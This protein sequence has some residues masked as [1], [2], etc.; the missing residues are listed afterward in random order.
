VSRELKYDIPGDDC[1]LTLEAAGAQVRQRGWPSLFAPGLASPKRLV[2][3]IGFGRGEFLLQ[4]ARSE[5]E[6]GFLGIERSFKRVLKMARRLAR[7]EIRN[8]RLIESA[9]ES[10]VTEL[11]PPDSVARCWINFPDPWPKKRHH[12][13]RLIAPSFVRDVASRLEPHG[14]LH[15]ATD[16]VEYAEVIDGILAAEPRLENAYAPTRYRT[17]VPGRSPTA[18]EA[19]WRAQGRALHFFCY[20]RAR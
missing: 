8:V 15:I 16:H 17:E 1:R 4:L 19:E 3:D 18:Y 14:V 12:R 5:P 7:S 10:V 13:R 11:L 2:V 9:A 20:H 6:S